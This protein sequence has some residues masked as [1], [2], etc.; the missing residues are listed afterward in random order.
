MRPFTGAALTRVYRVLCFTIMWNRS[1]NCSYTH[2]QSKNSV[3]VPLTKPHSLSP[4]CHHIPK[5]SSRHMPILKR[6]CCCCDITE[7]SERNW[8]VHPHKFFPSWT[9]VGERWR[10][11]WEL[12]TKFVSCFFLFLFYFRAFRQSFLL[13]HTFVS[14]LHL[15]SDLEVTDLTVCVQCMQLALVYHWSLKRSPLHGAEFLQYTLFAH[16]VGR[17]D[18]ESSDEQ[19]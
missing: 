6:I 19:L 14:L 3:Q 11:R 18:C 1:K 10:W 5:H 7:M 16:L 17:K 2:W 9:A 15:V 8:P 4:L 12:K 13:A